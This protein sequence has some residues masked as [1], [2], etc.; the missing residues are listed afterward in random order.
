[1]NQGTYNHRQ[2]VQA[3]GSPFLGDSSGESHMG[4][5][6]RGRDSRRNIPDKMLERRGHGRGAGRKIGVGFWLWQWG[7]SL[8][9][10][11]ASPL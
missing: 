8:H 4:T 11:P 7:G 6:Y 9:P 3:G 1:M 10:I 2:A 5:K